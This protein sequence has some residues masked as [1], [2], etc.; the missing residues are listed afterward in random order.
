MNR[1]LFFILLLLLYTNLNTAQS[2]EAFKYQ[3][4]ARDAAGQV[5]SNQPI[6]FQMSILQGNTSGINVYTETHTTITNDFGLVNLEIGNGIFMSGNFSDIDWGMNNYY[7]QIEMDENGG[8]NFQIMGVSQLL[9]VPYAIHAKTAENV[10]GDTDADP[11]NEIQDISLVGHDLTLS[12][13]STLSLPDEVNDADADPTNEIELPTGGNNGQVLTTDGS[14]NYSWTSLEVNSTIYNLGD[15]AHGGI[16]FWVNETGKHGLVCAKED[17]NLAIQWYNNSYSDT[18]S[19]RIG[20]YGGSSNTE[21]ITNTQGSGYYAAYVCSQYMGGDYGDW[22]LPS[23]GELSLMFQQKD[24]V[25]AAATVNGGSEFA[26]EAYWSS[27]ELGNNGAWDQNFT[28][29]IQANG[30][31]ADVNHVRAI[32]AF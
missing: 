29:G 28:S 21:R 12:G 11:T 20:V 19:M 10:P 16:V 31:K 26:S 32:R 23:K 18:R 2:P 15:F 14:G 5:L 4:V 1:N 7:V 30:D 8:N 6:S 17:Q 22:Y 25:N 9:S 27:T 13:G 24:I 3:A